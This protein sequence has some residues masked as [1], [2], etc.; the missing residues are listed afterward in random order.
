[1]LSRRAAVRLTYV[2]DGI[3]DTSG[4]NSTGL[5]AATDLAHSRGVLILLGAWTPDSINFTQGVDFMT[6]EIETHIIV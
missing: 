3:V 5:K 1:M 2:L 4:I 6:N